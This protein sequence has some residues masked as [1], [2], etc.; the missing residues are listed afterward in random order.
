MDATFRLAE[1]L[2]MYGG[3]GLS[4]IFAFVV[5]YLYLDFRK[6]VRDKDELIYKLNEQHHK[7]IVDVVKE[8]V[9]VLTS[10]NES[11]ERCEQR[12]RR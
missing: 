1:F 8:C 4:S 11:L 9:G 7:E 6:V 10:V 3:W 12:Q 5:I 2:Q